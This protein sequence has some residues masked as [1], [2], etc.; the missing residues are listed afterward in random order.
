MPSISHTFKKNSNLFS[1]D[2]LFG[3]QILNLH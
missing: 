1:V 3:K 2:I